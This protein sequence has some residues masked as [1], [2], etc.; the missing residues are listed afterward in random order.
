MSMTDTNQAPPTTPPSNQPPSWTD[1]LSP[2]L[3]NVVETKGYKSPADVVN[4]YVNAEKLIGVDKIPVPKDGIWDATARQKLGVPETPDKY[5][6][7]KP[8]LPEGMNWD[9][10][11]EKAAL[12]KA[13]EL[14]LTPTQVKGLMDLYGGTQIGKFGQIEQIIQ[15]QR[16][17]VSSVL[18]Q[19]WGN[20]FAVKIDNAAR[21]A[22][23]LGGD[24]LVEAL[25]T[26][27]AGNNAE[28]IRAFAKIGSMLGED[29]IK[30][31]LPSGFG[32]TPEEARGEAN[33]LMSS[34]AYSSSGHPEHAAVVQ[35]V[36][37][38]FKQAYPDQN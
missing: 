1:G 33:K 30:A 34:E 14:G 23:M 28:I 24:A 31:G 19:E 36:Q 26:S 22:R 35:K 11:F 7:E 15:Q 21:A 6:I 17:E 38:L 12:A 25:E 2:E 32:L 5:A 8:I 37:A 29:K 16:D 13:H 9:A 4:A 18:K 20:A 10:D 3:K 27:G